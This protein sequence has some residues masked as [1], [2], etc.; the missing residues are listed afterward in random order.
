MDP[1][2]W[3]IYDQ[4]FDPGKYQC[5]A[6]G[7]LFDEE[8]HCIEWSEEDDCFIFQCPDCGAVGWIAK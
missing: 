2:E 4:F 5:D 3:F 1:M 6:C 8:D 7:A